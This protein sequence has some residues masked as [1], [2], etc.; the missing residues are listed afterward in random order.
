ALSPLRTAWRLSPG[1]TQKEMVSILLD[2]LL[3]A[4]GARL[5]QGNF[6][7]SVSLLKEALALAPNADQVKQP[8]LGALLAYGGQLLSQGNASEAVSAYTEAT[9]LAP[10][11]VEGYIGLARSFFQSGD[12]LGALT[13]AGNAMRLAP[14]NLD[15]RSLF[16]QLQRR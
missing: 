2:T 8:M 11:G 5:S 4:A 9:Q 16:Q 1:E 10:Q 7:E 15:A 13:A 6:Q 12:F 14:T 3:G